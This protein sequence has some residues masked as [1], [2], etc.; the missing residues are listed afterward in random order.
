MVFALFIVLAGCTEKKAPAAGAGNQKP[1]LKEGANLLAEINGQDLNGFRWMNAP[2]R[3]QASGSSIQ[4][5]VGEGT[6]FFNSPEDNTIAATASLL[7]REATGDFVAT[8]L[9]QPDFSS[10][11]NAAAL[12]AHIDSLN[13]IKFAFENSDATGPG[14]VSVVTRGVSDD[15]NGPILEGRASIWLRIIRKGNL[16]A[17]HW[18]EN[19]RDFKMAR[20]SVLPESDTVKIGMEAQSPVGKTATHTFLY[21]SLEERTVEDMRKGE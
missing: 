18:S 7:Y 12:M 20:L 13:W 1:A 10:V 14:I 8:A 15:A 2:E 11:W 6:D 19:G 16:Y 9:V 21:F 17:L 4:A 3:L 5:T